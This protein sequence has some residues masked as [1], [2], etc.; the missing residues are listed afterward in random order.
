[1]QRVLCFSIVAMYMWLMILLVALP[2]SS[3][4]QIPGGEDSLHASSPAVPLDS[5]AA[6]KDSLTAA[7]GVD[8]V[9]TY[10][11][12]DSILYSLPTKTMSLFS[13]GQVGEKDME[14]RADHIDIN[15]NTSI[16]SAYGIPDTSDSTK[17]K[18]T[19]TPI[20]KDGKEEYHGRELSY[21][22]QTKKGKINVGETEVDRG[23]YHGEDIKKVD[24]DILFIAD[25]RYT[26]CN[27]PDPDYY[28]YSPKMK[29]TLQ[30]KVVAEPVYLAVADVPVFWLPFAVFPN[31]A[32]R[33]SGIIA[34]AYGED[35]QRGKFLSHLGYY[36]ALSDYM[37]LGAK[38]DLYSKGGW[39]A[40]STYR[41]AL[42]YYFSGSID[43]EYR[44][45]HTGESTDPARTEVESYRLSLLH[46][47]ILDPTARLDVN[48]TF[49][50]QNSYRNTIDLTQALEQSIT[51]N[52]TLSKTWEGSPNSISFNISRVQNL[53]DG[54]ISQTLPSISFNH[55][56]SYPFRSGKKSAGAEDL[57]WYEM[58]GM[59]YNAQVSNTLAKIDRKIDSIKVHAGGKDTLRLVED[60][61]RDHN[62]SVNQNISFNIAPKLGR[63]T[64]SPSVSYS[65]Q[66]SF[67]NNDVPQRNSADSSLI[68]RN[69]QASQRNG[70]FA[71]GVA[72]S[73]K[74][75]GMFQ[76]G[77]L[78]IAALRHTVSPSLSFTYSKQ[79]IGENLPRKQMTLGLNVGNLFEMKTISDEE[80]KE[81][82][83]IQLLNFDG[84]ISY[85]FAA[86]SLNFSP[87]GVSYRTGIGDALNISGGAGFDLYKLE[88]IGPD[89]Y[90]RVNKFLI[91]EEGRLA[92]LTN[93]NINFSTSL[94][95]ER[96]K[97]SQQNV[98]QDTSAELQ[99]KSGSYGIYRE[100]EPDF[101]IPWR[102]SLSL[103][104]AENKIPPSPSR[105][106]NLGASLEFNLTQNWKFS[107][108]SG[109][110]LVN[111]EIVLPDIRISRDLHCWAMDF[112]WV[113]TGTYRHYKLEIH[114]KEPQLKDIKV[115]KQGSSSGIY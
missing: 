82:K 80:G 37:D 50:S 38:T 49:A 1:M 101:S 73:T 41:Y 114:V 112:S 4:A 57:A 88:Q 96:K 81:G 3:F 2:L 74:F 22:F 79:I 84:N 28:F 113:P 21:D 26:T 52:A 102:L 108:R 109:Y 56:Q 93:F 90:V 55:A 36:W 61:E 58:I 34:P 65:D 103:D 95:G 87:I 53:I 76:P 97:S 32:G 30:D 44:K 104:Y 8:T 105:S 31:R 67:A 40:F 72:A 77:M 83:K 35:G 99:Q 85:D 19:G 43:G 110:D 29:V 14:L 27:K 115:T 66:R 16:L 100:E 62:Q 94:S 91:R 86:D 20:M 89:Q 78:G 15:W 54:S 6:R 10:S 51:S 69:V 46:N 18:L 75:Y 92:R 68:T 45:L 5:A 64:I 33:R 25:G 59:S 106:S 39:A 48:F 98:Q 12:S 70:F 24:Q 7:G 47:Q 111:R 63:F 11:C 71:T 23:F 9:V 42:Q 107:A 17:K 13:K 60:F